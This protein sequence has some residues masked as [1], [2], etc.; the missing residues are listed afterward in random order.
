MKHTIEELLLARAVLSRALEMR[1]ARSLKMTDEE[2]AE[3]L[4]QP[5]GD[6]LTEAMAELEDVATFI[7]EKRR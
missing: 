2:L 1:R 3:Y 6:L 7:A 5:I 4:R